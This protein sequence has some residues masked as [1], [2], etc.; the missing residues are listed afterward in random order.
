MAAQTVVLITG[1]NRGRSFHFFL[2]HRL[3]ADLLSGIG[4]AMTAALLLRPSITVVATV[5]DPSHPT[6]KSLPLLPTGADSKLVLLPLD[7]KDVALLSS[8]LHKSGVDQLD[9]IIS[10]AGLNSSF[11]SVEAT[12]LQAMRDDFE[13]NVVGTLSLFQVCYPLLQEGQAKKF[14]VITSSV[15]SIKGLEMENMPGVSYGASKAAVNWVG[16]KLSIEYANQ[17]FK[18]GIVHPG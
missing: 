6:S 4:R 18:I 8:T 3:K 16:K 12:A 10:N 13:V 7:L 17:G 5:R 2:H 14:V 1:A 15:G 9:I 11:D